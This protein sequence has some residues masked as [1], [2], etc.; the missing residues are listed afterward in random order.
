M[1]NYPTTGL[2]GV[3]PAQLAWF[4]GKWQGQH[5]QD[6]V[7]EHWSHLAGGALMAMFRWLREGQVWF[8]EF[9]TIEQADVYVMLRIKH[10]YPGLKGWEEKDEATEFFLVALDEREAVFMQVH[11]PGNWLIYRLESSDKLVVYFEKDGETA[12]PSTY[13]NYRRQE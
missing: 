12:D 4:E 11:K 10:F 8:Y 6:E 7:E 2:N 1:S 13:F 3:T 5:G 9:R